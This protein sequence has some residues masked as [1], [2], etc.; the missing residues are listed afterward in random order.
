MW[1]LFVQRERPRRRRMFYCSGFFISCHY[2]DASNR[3]HLCELCRPSR[4]QDTHGVTAEQRPR[5]EHVRL[6]G[7]H[8][9]RYAR[10]SGVF[11][12]VFDDEELCGFSTELFWTESGRRRLCDRWRWLVVAGSEYTEPRTFPTG[13]SVRTGR[14][15]MLLFSLSLRVFGYVFT[16]DAKSDLPREMWKS[17]AID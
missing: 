7:R 8:I 9:V 13:V 1:T 14:R 16:V 12:G 2:V 17:A 11:G 3:D 6:G 5:V 4:T 10:R 15:F